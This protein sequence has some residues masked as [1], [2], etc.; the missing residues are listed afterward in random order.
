MSNTR[1]II[2]DIASGSEYKALADAI[3]QTDY[4]AIFESYTSISEL[5]NNSRGKIEEGIESLPV[6]SKEKRLVDFRRSFDS[7]VERILPLW[8]ELN[9]ALAKSKVM[10]GEVFGIGK[11]GDPLVRTPDGTI[12]ALRGSKLEEGSQVKFSVEYEG[13]KISIGRV[14]E[15]NPQS[16]YI[17]ITQEHRE[18]INTTFASIENYLNKAQ[19]GLNEDSL[20]L[21]GE[22]LVELGKIEN[23]PPTFRPEERERIAAQALKYRKRLI[24]GLVVR[25]MFDFLSKKEEE[26]IGAFYRDRSEEMS[27][28]LSALGLFRRHTYEAAE[29]LLLGDK[30]EHGQD[31]GEIEDEIDSMDSAM[32]VLEYQEAID[33]AYPRA[34]SYLNKMNHIFDRL[35]ERAEQVADSLSETEAVDLKEI[36]DA[37]ETAFGEDTLSFELRKAFRNSKEFLSFRGAFSQLI[38]AQK[39]QESIAADSAFI[40]YLHHKIPRI[41]G[42]E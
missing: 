31:S 17:T 26:A 10:D 15:L 24:Y 1:K 6:G 23:P 30:P 35:V 5:I 34:K 16:F 7:A 18:R 42:I 37:I 40:S 29:K 39:D 2:K 3:E 19:E 9:G 11:K 22:L 33:R 13:E 27:Q 21:S 32:K 28:A 8:H 25:S 12:V 14:F 41:F 4:E 20:S 38:K 36:Q